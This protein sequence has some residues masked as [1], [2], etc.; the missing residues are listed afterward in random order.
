MPKHKTEFDETE[1]VRGVNVKVLGVNYVRDAPP[2]WRGFQPIY[3]GQPGESE[4][5]NPD[6]VKDMVENYNQGTAHGGVQSPLTV[7]IGHSAV[8]VGTGQK[9]IGYILEMR[10]LPETE[11]GIIVTYDRYSVPYAHK[12][13]SSSLWLMAKIGWLKAGL[14]LLQTGQVPYPSIYYDPDTH[15]VNNLGIVL[16]PGMC[17]V[18]P[19][20][21][22]IAKSKQGGTIKQKGMTKQM[23][24]KIKMSEAKAD[25][26]VTKLQEVA[27]DEN[28]IKIIV[29]A[30]A[31]VD[32][33]VIDSL[34][35]LTVEPEPEPEPGADQVEET[36]RTLSKVSTVGSMTIDQ[37]TQLITEAVAKQK[38]VVETDK[39]TKAKT[40][41]EE[42]EKLESVKQLLSSSGACSDMPPDV[43]EKNAKALSKGLTKSES[44]AQANSFVNSRIKSKLPPNGEIG[45]FLGG[46]GG[47]S[48]NFASMT[49]NEYSNSK[50]GGRN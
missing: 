17:S 25:E 2:E 44:I 5:M 20:P 28:Q 43:L 11:E 14:D 29:E 23:D 16:V 33:S 50:T 32:D 13:K 19:L 26:L 34:L 30:L 42:K 46:Q 31:G 45:S 1:K 22:C 24:G 47:A 7:D 10:S 35:K 37:L 18:P 4:D 15:V 6:A 27:V 40:E 36:P 12:L 41:S 49:L 38:D 3:Y 39:V 8:D 21:T 9:S 48:E